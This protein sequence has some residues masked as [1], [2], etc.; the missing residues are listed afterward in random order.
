MVKGNV[1]NT[2]RQILKFAELEFLTKGFDGA[3]TTSIA[4]AAGVTHAMLHYYFRTK[5]LLFERFIEKKMSEIAPLMTYMI[6]NEDL[7][8]IERIR[9]AVSLHFDFV[10]N[11][12]E[13]P[14]F[15]INEILPHPDR[16][17]SLVSNIS[18]ILAS[19]D[20]LQQE[21]NEASSKGELE[22]FNVLMLFQSILSMNV[23]P[24]LMSGLILGVWEQKGVNSKDY[25]ALRKSENI[26]MIMR[27][28]TKKASL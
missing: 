21:V 20:T 16:C 5:E 6:G 14:R 17:E 27:R 26:E 9:E 23:F 13:L 24:A 12:P 8:L 4:K 3:R 25:M 7:P 1:H 19:F 18:D 15:L 28:I 2:E 22:H 10:M 11:N